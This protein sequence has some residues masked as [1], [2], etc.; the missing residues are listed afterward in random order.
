MSPTVHTFDLA[1][2][3]KIPWLGWGNGSGD[4]SKVPVEGGV[5]ALK[6]G[7]SHIDTAQIYLNE[8]FLTIVRSCRLTLNPYNKVLPRRL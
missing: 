5:T 1:S 6:A 4:A 3:V 8:G 2:G 7:I